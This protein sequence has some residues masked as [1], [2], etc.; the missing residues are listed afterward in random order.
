MPD[1]RDAHP[2]TEN[3]PDGR[4][5]HPTTENIPDGRDAHPTTENIPDGRDAHPTK[6]SKSSRN[7][8]TPFFLGAITADRTRRKYLR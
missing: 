7:Y 8:A 1:G 3:T 6:Q 4:D 5:A 2:T